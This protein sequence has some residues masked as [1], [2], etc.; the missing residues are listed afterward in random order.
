MRILFF[1]DII[2]K[3]GRSAIGRVLAELVGP[4]VAV[5]EPGAAV[6]RHLARRLDETRLSAPRKDGGSERFWTSGHPA[7][8][9]GLVARLWRA[10][11][12]LE[13]L[14]DAAA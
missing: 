7:A 6:A 13:P 11:V 8:A 9:Q 12:T 1:G 5:V 4:E 10:P 2:G 14:P 3:P